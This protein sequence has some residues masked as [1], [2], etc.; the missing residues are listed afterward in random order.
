MRRHS[1]ERSSAQG[2]RGGSALTSSVPAGSNSRLIQG[3]HDALVPVEVIGARAMLDV[4]IEAALFER[5]SN[6]WREEQNPRT[7]VSHGMAGGIC[8]S[9]PN[10]GVRRLRKIGQWLR[11]ASDGLPDPSVRRGLIG[12]EVK[13]SNIK[14][15]IKKVCA[16]R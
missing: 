5:M 13:S 11:N 4:L 9:R 10:A 3:K 12:L 16:A 8:H 2:T 7:R 15:L 6:H 1:S 14:Y